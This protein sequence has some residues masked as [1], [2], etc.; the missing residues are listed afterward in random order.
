MSCLNSQKLENINKYIALVE[1]L[2]EIKNIRELIPYKEYV[3]HFPTFPFVINEELRE[4]FD[5]DLLQ[6]LIFASFSSATD[7]SWDKY[8]ELPDLY[9][10]VLSSDDDGK[11][12]SVIKTINELT[13]SQVV[14]L[15]EIYCE[16]IMNIET[17]LREDEDEAAAIIRSRNQK[18]VEA[19]ALKLK[20]DKFNVLCSFNSK[21]QRFAKS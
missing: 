21:K 12:V 5:W 2:N 13:N 4:L 17:L 19:K 10:V 8:H 15:F 16:E 11:S 18:V 3:T 1:P 20:N 7:I 9:V 6:Q 14:R